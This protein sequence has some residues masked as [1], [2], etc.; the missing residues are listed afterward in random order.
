LTSVSGATPPPLAATTRLF[1][2]PVTRADGPHPVDGLEP[3]PF[4]IGRLLEDGDSTDLVWLVGAAGEEALAGWLS[5]RGRRQ[6]S[7][8]SR[9]F[10]SVLLA[11]P[12][13][14]PTDDLLWPL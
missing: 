1:P 2:D 13:T 7:R 14:D 10:W 9:A 4:V 11:E 12:H 5:A 3:T 8:R 6:L